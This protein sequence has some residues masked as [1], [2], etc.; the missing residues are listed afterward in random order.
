LLSTPNA[1][2]LRAVLEHGRWVN[3]VN[4]THFYYF[5]RHSLHAVLARAGLS[6][7]SEWIFP[8]DYPG[9]SAVR[10]IAHRALVYCRL[11]GQLLFVARRGAMVM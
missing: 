9:H 3:M 4:P 10:Q 6:Q 11:Q 1:L 7:A 8:I 2:C 5:T